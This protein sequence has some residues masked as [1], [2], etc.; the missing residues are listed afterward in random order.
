MGL[1][2]IVSL[3]RLLDGSMLKQRWWAVFNPSLP[4]HSFSTFFLYPGFPVWYS[5]NLIQRGHYLL[6]I[7]DIY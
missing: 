5:Y 2:L 6:R 7:P 1:C 3:E 4:I